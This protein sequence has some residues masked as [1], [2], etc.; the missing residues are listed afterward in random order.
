MKNK[1]LFKLVSEQLWEYEKETNC[2][3]LFCIDYVG[4]LIE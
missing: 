1:D 3:S 4:G 2:F